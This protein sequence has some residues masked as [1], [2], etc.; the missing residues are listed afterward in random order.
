VKVESIEL[1]GF[2]GFRHEIQLS[3]PSGFAV[4]SGRNGTGK[5]TICDAIEF[6][7]TGTIDKYRFERSGTESLG[8]YFWYCGSGAV[9]SRYVRVTFS[10]GDKRL[11]IERT[12]E[13]LRT[14]SEGEILSHLAVPEI[15]PELP[16]EELCRTSIIR[17]E[18]ISALSLDLKGT[19]LFQQ[20]SNALGGIDALKYE[21]RADDCLSISKADAGRA[22]SEYDTI[23]IQ[24]EDALSTLTRLRDASVAPSDI[25]DAMMT[26]SQQIADL[27]EDVGQRLLRARAVLAESRRAHDAVMRLL[28][29]SN[30]LVEK[31]ATVRSEEFAAK[32]AAVQEELER[33]HGTHDLTKVA[34]D[35]AEHRLAQQQKVNRVA[36]DLSSLIETGRRLGLHEG[37]C[38]L[39]ASTLDQETFQSGV[40]LAE[41][42]L[43]AMN[44]DMRGIQK[45][46]RDAKESLEYIHEQRSRLEEDVLGMERQLVTSESAERQLLLRFKELGYELESIEQISEVAVRLAK[47]RGR[48]ATIDH[49]MRVLESSLAVNA[50]AEQET[51]VASL[52]ANVAAAERKLSRCQRVGHILH[53]MSA[54]VI[55]TRNDLRAEMLAQIG[56]LLEELYQ[57]LNP[58][59]DWKTIEYSLRGDVRRF[60]TLRVGDDLN[61]QFIF[62]SGQRRA[63]GLAFLLSVSL[64]RQWCR[65]KTLILD[66]PVQHVDDYRALN[67]V[68]ILSALRRDDHQFICSAEDDALAA[69]LCRRLRSTIGSPGARFDFDVGSD[70][71][72]TLV[73]QESIQPMA[74]H[75]L[76]NTD[77]AMSG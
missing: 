11:T 19:A 36:A 63:A 22:Q 15:A 25:G 30:E 20:V 42:R 18:L 67:L 64:S 7:I 35:S 28:S 17:D 45:E 71:S 3:I 21:R 27:P 23:R 50:V 31:R 65:W 37:T 12:P 73:G 69:L 55:R 72:L 40:A 54:A 48:L 56:P 49:A 29:E 2:R 77:V 33:L 58:H 39:C 14:P 32:R 61:P 41:Q 53:E 6:A 8:D 70:G 34:I 44:T 10:N 60:L 24:L 74:S 38:P 66:D 51:R 62:S 75:V 59:V 68:E 52:R 13:G 57:R 1:S 5:S 4:I 46:L 47:E 76:S 26:L 9:G 16:L 43:S